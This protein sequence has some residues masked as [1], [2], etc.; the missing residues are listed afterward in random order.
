MTSLFL[1]RNVLSSQE[2]K[3]VAVV[4]IS[5]MWYLKV[6][7]SLSWIPRS[8]TCVEFSILIFHKCRVVSE[9]YLDQSVATGIFLL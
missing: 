7:S 9:Y 2:A 4:V 8:R 3:F 1:V 6:R 5:V